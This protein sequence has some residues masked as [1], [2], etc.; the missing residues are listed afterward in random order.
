MKSD[1]GKAIAKN[2]ELFTQIIEKVL[3]FLVDY[4]TIM[5]PHLFLIFIKDN[6]TLFTVG[7]GLLRF[8]LAKQHPLFRNP[9]LTVESEKF[10]W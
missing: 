10:V 2:F 4:D 7:R 9:L 8:A 5:I 3:N 1:S 6:Y